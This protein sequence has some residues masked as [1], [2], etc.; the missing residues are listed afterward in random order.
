MEEIQ[1]VLLGLDSCALLAS[2]PLISSGHTIN[3]MD[4]ASVNGYGANDASI[5]SLTPSI[6]SSLHPTELLLLEGLLP[7]GRQYALLSAIAR[8][9][10]LG[11]TEG[12]YASAV[13]A[14]LEKILS[15]YVEDVKCAKTPSELALLSSTYSLTFNLLEKITQ[16]K[17]PKSGP[18]SS[19]LLTI[20]YLA[21]IGDFLSNME[22]PPSFRQILGE[23]IWQAVLYTT[24]HYV[25]HGVVLYGRSDYFISVSSATSSL[26]GGKK[27]SAEAH[28]LHQ[29][30]LPPGLSV[31]LGLS[32]L[33]AGKARR[34]LL[35]EVE[36][37]EGDYLEQLAIGALDGAAES[38]FQTIFAPSLCEGGLLAVDEMAA[39]VESAR[40]LWT[41]ALWER[42]SRTAPLAEYLEAL[43][44]VFMCARG[45]LWH[46]F[47]E[48][49]FNVICSNRSEVL[50]NPHE[51]A[52]SKRIH[53][54]SHANLRRAVGEAFAYGLSVSGLAELSTYECFSVSLPQ[55]ASQLDTKTVMMDGTSSCM[56]VEDVAGSILSL[57]RDLCIV[58]TTPQGLQLVVSQKALE[59]YQ[60][61]FSLHMSMRFALHS[62]SILRQLFSDAITTNPK[63]STDLR[64]AYALFQM[65]HFLQTAVA[66]Y[67][68]IDVVLLYTH[69][70]RQNI[71]RCTSLQEAKHCHDRFIWN[72]AENSFLTEG[73]ERVLTTCRALE[74]CAVTLYMICVRYRLNYWAVDG[75]NQTPI[76]VAAALTALETRVRQKVLASFVSHLSV[77]SRHAERALWVRIDFSRYFSFHR[78]A[79]RD[80]GVGSPVVTSTVGFSV[81]IPGGD[82]GG[83]LRT[84]L[85]TPQDVGARG[86]T[87]ETKPATRRFHSTTAT[88][89]RRPAQG[90]SNRVINKETSHTRASSLAVRRRGPREG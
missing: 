9:T 1:C 26:S 51:H 13:G 28:T 79:N 69:E 80:S 86:T 83:N 89:H 57:V 71:E 30:L 61:L 62:L 45:D 43:Q 54:S 55:G 21:G 48:C 65:L 23:H 24:A 14:A 74:E 25:A 49:T 29:D 35:N 6:R 3:S 70:L 53:T 5:L 88:P 7:L 66:N 42:V 60:R 47:V 31:N 52:G 46:A 37:N 82:G 84:R 68:Q 33:A 27:C 75:V 87:E 4:D 67:F 38:V 15:C 12:L 44:V 85:E 20:E 64:R 11:R 90:S 76:E 8:D 72:I 16:Q 34:V 22:L 73:S 50:H 36:A 40:A 58:Y 39:R 19:S 56:A 18:S 32:I 59:Y 81:P 2:S 78:S 77:S 10:S 63:P 41:K 17:A